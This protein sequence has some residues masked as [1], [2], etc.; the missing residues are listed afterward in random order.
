MVQRSLIKAPLLTSPTI[1]VMIYRYIEQNGSR[2]HK[3]SAH[4]YLPP[5]HF[6]NRDPFF[7]LD[8]LW[9]SHKTLKTHTALEDWHKRL[10]KNGTNTVSAKMLGATFVSTIE[11][12]NL[13]TVLST[14]FKDWELGEDRMKSLVPFLGEGIFTSDGAAWQHSRDM[15]RPNFARSQIND[16]ELFKKHASNLIRAIPRDGTTMVDLQPLFFSASLDI[17]TQFLFG[18]STG[19]LDPSWQSRGEQA[20]NLDVEKFVEAFTYLQNSVSGQES[21]FGVLGL[22]LPDWKKKGYVRS[23]HAFADNLIQRAIADN[24]APGISEDSMSVKRYVFLYELLNQ[25]NDLVKIRSELLN[26]LL[27]GR[28]ASASLLSNVWFELSR[29]PSVWSRLQQ[30]I[31]T[32]ST[33]NPS[34]EELKALKYLHAV[35]NESLRLYPIVPENSRQ[36]ATDTILPLGGGPDGKAPIFVPK[37]DFV[38]WSLW[39]MHRRH[40]L[41]G[42]DAESFKPERWLDTPDHKGLRVGWEYLPFNGGP[43]ICLGQQFALTEAAYITVRLMQEFEGIESRDAEPWR[44]KFTLTCTG[45]GGCKVVLKPRG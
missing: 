37:G 20:G 43:R 4:N 31:G 3:A 30:E 1:V 5:P 8:L 29:R 42:V 33:S 25:T 34:F 2:Q 9:E 16:P 26:I 15:L 19:C 38:H 11:P 14:N 21:R 17:T 39:S 45:L 23:L 32:L 27:A 44:E 28:D 6:R 36:A 35:F 22:F 13:K 24:N 12:L 7:G 40:D 18:R 10:I 41:F